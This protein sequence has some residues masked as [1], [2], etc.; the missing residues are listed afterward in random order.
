MYTIY[1]FLKSGGIGVNS[2]DESLYIGNSKGEPV[3]LVTEANSTEIIKTVIEEV[4]GGGSGGGGSTIV[5][6]A[7]EIPR[8]EALVVGNVVQ[9]SG[10]NWI[11][12]HT[13]ETEAYLTLTDT[14]AAYYF[15]PFNNNQQSCYRFAG[16]E[17]GS[18]E[19]RWLK[20][21][22]AGNTT[23]KVFIATK[24]QLN[25]GFAYFNSNARRAA[26]SSYLTSQRNPNNDEDGNPQAYL[27][28]SNGAIYDFAGLS[29]SKYDFRPCVCIDLTAYENGPAENPYNLPPLGQ[30]T[31]GNTITWAN[32][33]WIVASTPTESIC[34]LTLAKLDGVSTWNELNNT[35]TAWSSANFTE[36]QL[37]SLTS[38]TAG[39]TSGKVFVA[40]SEQMN[41][42]FSYF[43]SNDR[44]KMD[45]SYWTSTDYGIIVKRPEYVDATGVIAHD[46]NDATGSM[47][48]RPSIA[49]NMWLYNWI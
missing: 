37:A 7:N 16:R 21:I 1:P 8:K 29:D 44:R 3:Q 30:I 41:G 39:N 48:F 36:V 14:C 4:S 27:I 23:G 35:C 13:T 26:S 34:Y 10:H 40:T 2:S 19:K 11:V 9:F 32:H 15:G 42:G 47:G 28:N 18:A 38:V 46:D 33:E 31:L 49:L 17:I 12:A 25:G 20:T 24:E 5:G 45:Q 22:T 43:N 6:V